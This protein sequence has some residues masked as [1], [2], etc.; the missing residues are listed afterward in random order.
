MS[1]IRIRQTTGEKQ[2][3][4]V[5]PKSYKIISGSVLVAIIAILLSREMSSV[6]AR[7]HSLYPMARNLVPLEADSG[8]P[9][10]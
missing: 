8:S 2:T 7:Q 5:E 3:F 1:I 9:K 4:L 6:E 10:R